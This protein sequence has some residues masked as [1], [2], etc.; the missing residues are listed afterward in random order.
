MFGL[1]LPKRGGQAISGLLYPY[2]SMEIKKKL[3]RESCR[4]DADELESKKNFWLP[5]FTYSV[6]KLEC[7][8]EF[9]R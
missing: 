9:L 1:F 5:P 3:N 6:D 4:G 2:F 8:F 7:F